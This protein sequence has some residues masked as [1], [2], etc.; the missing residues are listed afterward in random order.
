MDKY[1]KTPADKLNAL[2]NLKINIWI[3][4]ALCIITVAVFLLSIGPYKGISGI[5]ISGMLS[6]WFIDSGLLN[7][8]DIYQHTKNQELSEQ[9]I[10]SKRILCLYIIIDAVCVFIFL[11]KGLIFPTQVSRVWIVIANIV[12]ALF[13]AAA[14]EDVKD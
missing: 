1:D 14:M 8:K 9:A 6:L 12:Y 5:F 13:I 2:L 10:M 11:M 7:A 4:S 3:N